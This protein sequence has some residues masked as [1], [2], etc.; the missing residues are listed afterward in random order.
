MKTT[1][2]Q[3]L[4]Q[5]ATRETTSASEAGGTTTSALVL[6]HNLN[7]EK[8]TRFDFEILTPTFTSKW[9]SFVECS[10]KLSQPKVYY[11]F[12]ILHFFA[13]GEHSKENCS[14]PLPP[15]PPP[16]Q[17][18]KQELFRVHKNCAKHGVPMLTRM[19]DEGWPGKFAGSHPRLEVFWGPDS[20]MC[21]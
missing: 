14:S 21:C 6:L 4:S 7:I 16:P 8:F 3:T 13:N 10:L 1:E 11:F 9:M 12:V 17:K 5:C 19:T 18:K 2:A 15:P 20:L